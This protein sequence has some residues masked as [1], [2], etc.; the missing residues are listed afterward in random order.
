MQSQEDRGSEIRFKKS[1]LETERGHT[2]CLDGAFE[3][4]CHRAQLERLEVLCKAAR[5]AVTLD[6]FKER[7]MIADDY[8]GHKAVLCCDPLL[9]VGSDCS[10]P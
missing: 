10:K 1:I 4:T 3:C 9:A 6:R 8:N 2:S 5:A 7:M